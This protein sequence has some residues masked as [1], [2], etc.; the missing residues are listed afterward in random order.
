MIPAKNSNPAACLKVQILETIGKPG[1]LVKK[2][3]IA[4]IHGFPV[5][6]TGRSIIE[7]VFFINVKKGQVMQIVHTKDS[8]V[9]RIKT[10]R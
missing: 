5:K 1:S 3:G 6:G 10:K 2:V 8:F 7:G 9:K 4:G